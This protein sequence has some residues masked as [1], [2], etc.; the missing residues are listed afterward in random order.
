MLASSLTPN[1]GKEP[2]TQSTRRL[3]GKAVRQSFRSPSNLANV[4]FPSLQNRVLDEKKTCLDYRMN[5]RMSTAQIRILGPPQKAARG[6]RPAPLERRL[7][8]R[9]NAQRTRDL[10]QLVRVVARGSEIGSGLTASLRSDGA[11]RSEQRLEFRDRERTAG[12]GLK[13][14]HF[15]RNS[16]GPSM[17]FSPSTAAS[18]ASPDTFTASVSFL[19]LGSRRENA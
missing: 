9:S 7:H 8:H 15:R 2:L 12:T 6:N 16:C 17:I 5:A 3:Q 14:V 13:R 4:P 11:A 10:N 18:T 19:P 1:G